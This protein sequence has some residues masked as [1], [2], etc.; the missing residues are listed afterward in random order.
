MAI[1]GRNT[2]RQR[3]RRASR[4]SL[5]GPALSSPVDCTPWV[6]GGLWPA[7]LATTSPETATL[8]QYLHA[9]L[10][11]IANAANEELRNIRLL[12]MGAVTREAAETRAINAARGFAA[13]RVEST[14]RQLRR[15]VPAAAPEYPGYPG[16]DGTDDT[17]T[18]DADVDA[19]KTRQLTPITA[20]PLAAG[21]LPDAGLAEHGRQD[22]EPTGPQAIPVDEDD[23]H[24][25]ADKAD[26]GENPPVES[27]APEPQSAPAAQPD[28]PEPSWWATY[29]P[30]PGATETPSAQPPAGR[31]AVLPADVAAAPRRA[32]APAEADPKPLQRIVE[33]VARQE[34]GLRWAVG[35]R[36]DGT[37]VV[38]TDLAHGW[39]PPGIELPAGVGLLE[40]QRR[41]GNARALLGNVT[42]AAT[43]APGDSLGWATGSTTIEPSSE[44]RQLPAINDLGWLLSEATHWRDGLPRIAHTLAKAGAAGTGVVEAEIDV[45]RVHL[46]T[47]R[48]QLLAQYPDIDSAL[49]LNCLLLAAAEGMATG[50]RLSANYHFAWF[51]RLTPSVLNSM[52]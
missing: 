2:A 6:I 21:P 29:P 4:E 46:D 15:V 32:K 40:P 14:V 44:P 39:I 24:L 45:L 9:D 38:V 12:G 8:A 3:L 31:H 42:A 41:T 51:Q 16:P 13:R 22:P 17:A 26:E 48:Y 23:Q 34:P 36:D 47:A 7:E 35:D 25:P 49:L 28:V 20:E 1:L 5:E 50:D 10:R 11:R 33:F 18:S 37:T 30:D 19:E 43:Y 27:I 52:N